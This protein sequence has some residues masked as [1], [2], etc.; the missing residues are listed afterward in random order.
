MLQNKKGESSDLLAKLKVTFLFYSICF[1]EFT[2]S[3]VFKILKLSYI[4]I[5]VGIYLP[6]KST[7]F[8]INHEKLSFD[9]VT[10]QK[11]N[12]NNPIKNN[13]LFVIC[14]RVLKLSLDSSALICKLVY[15]SLLIFECYTTLVYEFMDADG[16][17]NFEILVNAFIAEWRSFVKNLLK[18]G[19]LR[20]LLI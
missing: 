2:K 18:L 8:T 17:K 6:S 4:Q 9:E 5:A 19:K 15:M 16:S 12:S 11:F 14:Q 13:F 7:N 20:F 10:L 3:M 1:M